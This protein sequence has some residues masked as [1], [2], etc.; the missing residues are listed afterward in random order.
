MVL[1]ASP[2]F[3][4]RPTLQYNMRFLSSIFIIACG[5]S[6][7]EEFFKIQWLGSLLVVTFY[8]LFIFIITKVIDSIIKIKI[9]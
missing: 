1:V 7:I 2:L 5:C 3:K 6:I 8:L 9:K 4:R